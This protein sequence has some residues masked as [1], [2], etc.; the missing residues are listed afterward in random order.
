MKKYISTLLGICILVVTS[1]SKDKGNYDL[2]SI[3]QV[4]IND[5][6]EGTI[7][8]FQYENLKLTPNIAQT[9]AVD[10]SNLV[11]SWKVYAESNPDSSYPIGNKKNL[12]TTIE[13]LP[14]AY[15]VLYTIKDLQT[16]VSVFK[17]YKLQVNTKFGEGW[18]ILEDLPNGKQEVS[19]INAADEVFHNLY[20]TANADQNLPDNSHTIKV[21]NS[22]NGSEQRIFVLA[23]GN[24]IE[25]NYASFRKIDELKDW[26]FSVPPVINVQSYSYG[27]LGGAAFIVND[28]EVYSLR[29]IFGRDPSY[30]F[31]APIKGDWKISPFVFPHTYDDYAL[32]Y[33]TKNQRF[34][35]H[36]LASVSPLSNPPGS[37]FDPGD[38]GKE[39][40]F[41]GA[42][43]N[44]SSYYNCLMKNDNDDKFFVYTVDADSFTDVIA[45]DKYE[46]DDAPELQNAGLFAFSGLYPHM[47]YAVNNKI[48]L[49]DIPA[50]K[51]RLAYSFPTGTEITA[52]ELKQSTSLV[53]NYPDDNKQLVVATYQA[54]EGKIYKFEISN[55]GDFAGDTYAKEYTG[56]KKIKDLEYK[57]RR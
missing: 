6:T 50:Q 57:N 14:G 12:D 51:S 41:G 36:S 3:N 53:V 45:V 1:C 29:Y 26:F 40:V 15:V 17:E 32:L 27:K 34:L 10:E 37:A 47:Y 42:G 9:M 19:M 7:S 33:D 21:V 43:S 23:H 31:G 2:V 55:T 18:L 5:P 35:A 54:G 25:L 11:Y 8:V 20:K 13:L 38:V 46:V 56:F 28:N 48:Y 49:L 24:A 52:I 22:G 16:G 39:M 44:F 4:S 30:K